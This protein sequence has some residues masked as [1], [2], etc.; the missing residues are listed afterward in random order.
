MS[1]QQPTGAIPLREISQVVGGE[2]IGDPE[3]AISGVSSLEEARPGDLVYVEADRLRKI[4]LQSKAAAFVVKRPLSEVGRPQIIVSQPNYALALIVERFFIPR[5]A[6]RGIAQQIVRDA[7]VEIG[8]EVS[9]WPFVT[10]GARAR[11]GARV[12]LYPGV[13]IGEDASVGDDS[14]LYPNVTVRERCAVGRRVIIH[15]GAVIGSDGFGFVEHEGRH[16]KVPQIGS[17]VIEDDVE[18]G[19]NV[20][21]D[22]ATFGETVIKRGTKVDNLVHI[23]HNVTVG[24][25]SILIAQVG[26]AGSTR[27]GSH[28]V[29]GGQAGIVGHLKIG[30][31][32]MIAAQSGVARDLDEGLVVSGSPAIPRDQWTKTQAVL[33]RLPELRARIRE[34]EKRLGKIE[35][36]LPRSSKKVKKQK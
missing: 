33:P 9:I 4:A 26:I 2:I 19:A 16:Q 10:L 5:Y 28:V 21:V 11:I 27:L 29:V 6:P 1:S 35:A 23:A 12:T 31:R 3:T 14:I 22:R 30:D 32:V 18:L 8:P 24:E 7:D 34:M 15:S 17:V 13:F 20:A 36:R 25:D